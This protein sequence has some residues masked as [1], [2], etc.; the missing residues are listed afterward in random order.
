MAAGA[1][2]KW[3]G[4]DGL[5]DEGDGLSGKSCPAILIKSFH[6]AHERLDISGSIVGVEPLITQDEDV[7]A[8]IEQEAIVFVSVRHTGGIAVAGQ[9]DAAIGFGGEK[10]AGE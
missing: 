7:E 1:N 2:E 8:L 9:H 3:R 4:T 5:G 6:I 10:P